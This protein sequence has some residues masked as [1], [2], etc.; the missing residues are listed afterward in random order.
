MASPDTRDEI[1]MLNKTLIEQRDGKYL[2]SSEIYGFSV[3]LNPT[4]KKGWDSL[5][6]LH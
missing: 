3:A 4:P 2:I 5:C 6:F 1:I